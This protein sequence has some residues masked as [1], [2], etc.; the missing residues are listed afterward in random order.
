[1]NQGMLLPMPHHSTMNHAYLNK[2]LPEG[3][4]AVG[5]TSRFRHKFVTTVYYSHSAHM[6]SERP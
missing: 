3:L 1:M 4:I 5:V 2:G 6:G